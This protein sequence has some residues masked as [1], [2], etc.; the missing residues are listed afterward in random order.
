M[1]NSCHVQRSFCNTHAACADASNA[2]IRLL[3]LTD[4]LKYGL[5]SVL[6]QVYGDVR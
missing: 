1:S 3:L 6:E 5:G 2:L 4:I